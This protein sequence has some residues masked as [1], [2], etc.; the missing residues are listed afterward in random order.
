ML[1]ITYSAVSHIV[2][3][4]KGRMKTESDFENAYRQI[5]SQIKM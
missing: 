3:H 2:K 5:N 1:G 4:V